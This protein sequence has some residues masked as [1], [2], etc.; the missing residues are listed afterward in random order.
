M[1]Q[2]DHEAPHL[3]IGDFCPR[4]DCNGLITTYSTRVLGSTRVR[5]FCCSDCRCTESHGKYTLPAEYAPH[6]PAKAKR[7]EL[8]RSE[9]Q[10]RLF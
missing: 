1:D 8:R 4:R 10:R 2:T 3:T 9:F 5:Y 6:R 7:M